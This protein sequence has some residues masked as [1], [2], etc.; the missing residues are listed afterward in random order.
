MPNGNTERR[1]NQETNESELLARKLTGVGWGLFFIWIGIV[2]L[3]DAP[4]GIGLLGV[5][6]ITLGMQVAR[7]VF[8]LA[9]E[10][11]WL[12]VGGLFVLGG[13]IQLFNIQVRLVPVLLIVAGVVVLITT[14]TRKH[15]RHN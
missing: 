4:L 3:A 8:N 7:K 6:I 11:G 9:F 15:T 14:L 2:F 1:E 13:L 12:V 5:G 10:A